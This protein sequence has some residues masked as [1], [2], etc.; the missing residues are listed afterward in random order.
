MV[1]PPFTRGPTRVDQGKQKSSDSGWAVVT[2]FSE[3]WA[4]L[5]LW[6]L[7]KA[8]T[9]NKWDLEALGSWAFPHPAKC[10]GP[11]LSAFMDFR[12]QGSLWKKVCGLQGPFPSAVVPL[13]GNAS[14]SRKQR[15]TNTRCQ[16]MVAN[17][18]G[19][20]K[21]WQEGG[22]E[23]GDFLYQDGK[24]EWDSASFLSVSTLFFS[25]LLIFSS[26]FWNFW[27]GFL[28]LFLRYVLRIVTLTRVL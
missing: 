16:R 5:W 27:S 3:C 18:A 17:S 4:R 14:F 23:E 21:S 12:A 11:T 19:T 1:W 2:V 13:A 24:G 9:R 8:N 20:W 6:G 26:I 25:Y 10:F 22:E 28:F 15:R 7:P